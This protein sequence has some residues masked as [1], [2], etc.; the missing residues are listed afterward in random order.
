MKKRLF[1]ITILVLIVSILSSCS[2]SNKAQDVLTKYLRFRQSAKLK[3]VKL[4]LP[5]Y[6]EFQFKDHQDETKYAKIYN[7]FEFGQKKPSRKDFMLLFIKP[8]VNYKI[9]DVKKNSSGLVTTKVRQT[10]YDD[11]EFGEALG[12]DYLGKLMLQ[13]DL[14]DIPKEFH[15]DRLTQLADLIIN[16]FDEKY[17]NALKT[18]T[19]E[20]EVTYVL[21]SFNGEFKILGDKIQSLKALNEEAEKIKKIDSIIKN[22]KIIKTELRDY[23]QLN[24]T[25]DFGICIS[26]IVKN[27]GDSAI[28]NNLDVQV[29]LLDKE[30]KPVSKTTGYL[31]TDKLEPNFSDDFVVFFSKEKAVD[32]TG[33]Y[34]IR[35]GNESVNI[36][37]EWSYYER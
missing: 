17:S 21:Q 3:P 11:N 23:S 35:I 8:I 20:D 2:R 24:I 22:L 33:G 25:D 10:E 5:P 26:G 30:N 1:I 9:I 36:F 32:W 13:L 18:K 29:E 4:P 12:L 7:S 28:E 27:V 37:G 16:D 31:A 19:Y 15:D 14:Y 6:L 34:R